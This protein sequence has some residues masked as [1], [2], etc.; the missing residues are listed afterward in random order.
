MA[1]NQKNEQK[2]NEK[3]QLENEKIT[4]NSK[5]KEEIQTLIRQVLNWANSK[6]SVDY[7]P[8]L[9]DEKDSICIGIDLEKS[10]IALK[11]FKETGFFANEF[12]E[13][14]NQIN[15]TLDKKIRNNEFDTWEIGMLPTFGITD[16]NAW[17]K[18]QDYPYDNPKP[19]DLVEVSI[20]KLDNEK[21]EMFWN[22]GSN[23]DPNWKK[24]E[25]S[26]DPN[27]KFRVVKEG[28][29]W[30]ISYLEL[31]DYEQSIKKS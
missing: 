16:V 1:C 4:E 26:K 12:I 31:F 20:F 30:K 7:S 18:C 11:K 24:S 17:C 29:R 19:W 9:T 27:Y 15:I 5:D 25:W 23:G 2:E 28:G 21:G 22:W 13:N 14:L 6:N 10:K 3:S 8:I